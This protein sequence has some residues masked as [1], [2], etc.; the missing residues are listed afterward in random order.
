MSGEEFKERLAEFWDRVKEVASNIWEEIVDRVLDWWDSYRRLKPAYQ[1]GIA[2][3]VGLVILVV[4]LASVLYTPQLPVIAVQN[5]EGIFGGNWIAIQNQSNQ[6]LK[7]LY[8]IIDDKYIY[9]LE[10]LK[11]G[12]QV[13]IF[14]RDFYY[15]KGDFD[16]GEQVG[17]DFVGERLWVVSPR[18]EKEIPLVEKKRGLFR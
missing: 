10:N 4:I 15:R 14:N 11:A 18:G 17:Q 5:T 12:E 2:G 9:H 3:G 7:E 13:K 1:I 8:L 16:L 6:D